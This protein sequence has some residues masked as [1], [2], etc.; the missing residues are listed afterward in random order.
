MRYLLLT[1]LLFPLLVQ[2]QRVPERYSEVL[3]SAPPSAEDGR[4]A[5]QAIAARLAA[6]GL[7]LDHARAE[8]TD[9]GPALRTVLSEAE[10]AAAVASGLEVEVLVEDLTAHYLA[11]R[12]GSCEDGEAISRIEADLCGPMG[13][14]LTF[15]GVVAHLDAMHAQY[16]NLITAPASLGQSHEGRDVWMVE[17]S[18]NPGQEENEGE[19]LYTAVHHAR[20]PGGM[21]AVLYFMYYLLE[22]YGSD[23]GVTELVDTRRLF[24]VP[25]LNPDG[26]VYNETTNPDGGGYWR[27]NRRD[28]GGNVYGVDLNRNYDYL[29][30]Y[31]DIGSSPF[32]DS[33]TYRGPE[34]FSEPETQALRDFLE[35]GR[36]ISH[37]YN[38]HTYSRLLL[39]SWSYEDGAYTED[40]AAF[41]ALAEEATAVN[42]YTYGTSWAVLY[43]VNGGSD[44]WMYGEQSTKPKIFAF[45]PEVGYDFWPDP[46]DVYPLADENLEANLVLA[47]AAVPPTPPVA[48][49]PG[50]VSRDGVSLGGAYP[51]P[52]GRSARLAFTLRDAGPVRLTLHDVL[53]REVAVLW[54]G[55]AGAGRSEATLDGTELPS[56]TYVARLAAGRTVLARSVT[57]LR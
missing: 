26:Y 49:E 28:L 35:D 4:E 6:H 36:R 12:G 40:D 46:S 17:I 7:V 32:E 19:V 41:E 29:W 55:P 53:G 37:A 30:G 45:T 5:R 54:D 9:A 44:D 51:N 2:A 33:G 48:N 52:F 16:P 43:P 38:Y 22:N 13:G 42:N 15:D 47:Q 23:D 20:E 14:Y 57:V 1:A 50:V 11:T 24:F 18:D 31:D 27:K 25:V 21:A 10:V 34:P 3:I 39:Y 56:G 8:T